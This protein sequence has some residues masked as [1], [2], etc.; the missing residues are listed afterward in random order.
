LYFV[1]KPGYKLSVVL[2][3]QFGDIVSQP[4]KLT[5][6]RGRTVVAGYPV[7]ISGS[8]ESGYV[9]VAG[10]YTVSLY[11]GGVSIFPD[12][13]DV[14]LGPDDADLEFTVN[15]PLVQGG[16]IDTGNLPVEDVDINVFDGLIDLP[17]VIFLENSI[18]RDEKGESFLTHV[19]DEAGLFSIPLF[20]GEYTLRADKEVIN[21]ENFVNWI[22]A[23]L[24]LSDDSPMTL[25]LQD[26]FD[27]MGD[28]ESEE[29]VQELIEAI[30]AG[31]DEQTQTFLRESMMSA[32][33]MTRIYFRPEQRHV[34]LFSDK[35][36]K[37]QY[38]V[39]EKLY[40]IKGTIYDGV[41]VESG[42][43]GAGFI[44]LASN[45]PGASGRMIY[46]QSYFRINDV[47]Y[48]E[49]WRGI[50]GRGL[51]KSASYDEELPVQAGLFTRPDGTYT[52]TSLLPGY[53][54][55]VPVKDLKFWSP[56]YDET[57]TRIIAWE[58]SGDINPTPY[59]LGYKFLPGSVEGM[60]IETNVD[61]SGIYHMPDIYA[62]THDVSA[63]ITDSEG[64]GISNLSVE[65]VG[66]E[67]V[68]NIVGETEDG[69][70]IYD[71]IPKTSL[72]DSSGIV[73]F[74][75]QFP[76][77]EYNLYFNKK[78]REGAE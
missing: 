36:V 10:E 55:V 4:V 13:V 68:Y 54:W 73:M 76:V 57:K 56:V 52:V 51:Y 59:N 40:T 11:R 34:S 71:R 25:L 49:N 31:Q 41:N 63:N 16:A 75:K 8:Y 78:R 74:E 2:R 47:E 42:L 69:E 18:E 35:S 17:E 77:G 72:T 3:N 27:A 21:V 15:L 28:E 6:L 5:V 58:W 45:T 1:G 7:D 33:V 65:L 43:G 48:S 39:T 24:G 26:L 29:F 38:F 46:S 14:S 66:G 23:Y 60:V 64:S 70:P 12:T 19:T 9:F 61:E 20:P 53:F 62:Y 37:N 30:M 67:Y 50:V 44:L 22:K 32:E